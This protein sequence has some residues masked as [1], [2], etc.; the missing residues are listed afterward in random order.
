M[1]NVDKRSL[2]IV[3]Q[4]NFVILPYGIRSSIKDTGKKE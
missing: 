1:A 3:S 2:A 4:M